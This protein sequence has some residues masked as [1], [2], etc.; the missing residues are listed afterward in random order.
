MTDL[1]ANS[2]WN[3]TER[4]KIACVVLQ[5]A[6]ASRTPL[7]TAELIEAIGA[8]H[9]VLTKP[10]AFLEATEQQIIADADK[11]ADDN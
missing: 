9:D 7:S 5:G 8:A 2:K 10:A 3:D 1:D 4:S 6:L 11:I